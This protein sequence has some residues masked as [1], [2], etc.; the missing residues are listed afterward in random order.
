M[1]K[2][3][4]II[5]REFSVRVKKKSFI[6]LTILMPFLV[7]A[8]VFVPALLANMKSGEKN[9]VALIDVTN[10]YVS[11]LKDTTDIHFVYET[12][13]K[14]SFQQD[15]SPYDAVVF[16]KGDLTHHPDAATIYSRGEVP[17]AVEEYVNDKLTEKIRNDKLSA[18]QFKDIKQVVAD[19]ETKFSVKTARWDKNGNTTVSSSDIA[20]VVGL[21][22]SLFIYMFILSY[23]GMVMQGIVEEKTN[24]IVEIMVSSVKPWQLMIGKITGVALVGL[25]QFVIWILMLTSIVA[26]AGSVFG[27][28]ST[29]AMPMVGGMSSE[30]P[31][32]AGL[33]WLHIIQGMNFAEIIVLFILYFIG[34]YL[35]F[36]SIFAAIG[37]SINEQ[38]DAQQFMMPIVLIFIFALYAGMFSIQNPD[39]P[40]ALWC[41]FIPFTSPVVM[42]VRVPFDLPL[43][44]IILSLVVLYGTSALIIWFSSKIYRVGILMYGKKPT[45]K[46]MMKWLNYK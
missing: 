13:M 10:H 17:H 36:A 45:F 20:G 31:Q 26:I 35:L 1:S 43:W 15:G 44:Q 40:L 29:G 38:Q 42:M 30:I 7:A 27:V 37:A 41:S 4:I 18:Y 16:I 21:V 12:T 6:I 2:I 39:G 8:L 33:E 24:R 19:A 46:D 3:W 22:F 25:F 32:V 28:A 9:T 11:V 14:K 34:G 23:G 5:Q